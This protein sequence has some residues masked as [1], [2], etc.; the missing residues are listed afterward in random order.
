[1]TAMGAQASDGRVVEIKLDER[2]AERRLSRDAREPERRRRERRLRPSLARDLRSPWATPPWSSPRTA[3]RGRSRPRP[4]R[5]W[6]GGPGRAWRQRAARGGA[7]EPRVVGI[8]PRVARGDRCRDRRGPVHSAGR[9]LRHPPATSV[10]PDDHAGDRRSAMAAPQTSIPPVAPRLEQPSPPP[11][12]SRERAETVVPTAPPPPASSPAPVRIVSARFSGVVLSVDPR[13]RSARAR[14][15]GSRRRGRA[16][17]HR[18]GARRPRGGVRAGRA[19]RGS[20]RPFK[21]TAIEPVRRQAR[22]LRGRGEAG[23]A[24]GKE[25]AR[26]V[27]V[28]F[29]HQ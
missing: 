15:P 24:E 17:A 2:R 21:D 20:S 7:A 27:V 5:P 16:S 25:L 23:A 6:S 22:R 29:R 18:A 3:H 11:P 10:A 13:A 1:M 9:P 8:A 12:A 28:T 26:S 14:G 19:G 4:R